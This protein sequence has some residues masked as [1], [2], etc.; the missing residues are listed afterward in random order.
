MEQLA[1]FYIKIKGM[2]ATMPFVVSVFWDGSI[3]FYAITSWY[4]GTLPMNLYERV[5]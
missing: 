3:L 4:S 5:G 1:S 2:V